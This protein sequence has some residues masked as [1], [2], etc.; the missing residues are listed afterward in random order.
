M[1]FSKDHELGLREYFIATIAA[2]YMDFTEN[3]S[4]ANGMVQNDWIDELRPGLLRE[5]EM[6][7]FKIYSLVLRRCARPNPDRTDYYYAGILRGFKCICERLAE[8]Q[9]RR[10]TKEVCQRPLPPC[11]LANHATDL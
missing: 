2:N 3:I 1:V 11:Q 9:R 10:F 7:L 6:V 8:E 4:T 5:G